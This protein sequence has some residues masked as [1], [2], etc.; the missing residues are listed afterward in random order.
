MLERAD[1]PCAGHDHDPRS[2]YY[3]TPASPRTGGRCLLCG[4]PLREDDDVIDNGH[5]E[6]HRECFDEMPPAFTLARLGWKKTEPS[7]AVCAICG[8]P[9]EPPTKG[10]ELDEEYEKNGKHIH[11]SCFWGQDR[12]DLFFEAL[13]LN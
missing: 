8:E 9:I 12:D 10:Y 13:G 1:D 5:V 4:R 3:T 2:P 6:M 11:L 7:C